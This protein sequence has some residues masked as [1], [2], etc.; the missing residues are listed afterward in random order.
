[1]LIY[2]KTRGRC[3]QRYHDGILGGN[4][5]SY[6]LLDTKMDLSTPDEYESA[7]TLEGRFYVSGKDFDNLQFVK[8]IKEM[9]NDILIEMYDKS[10]GMD[11]ELRIKKDHLASLRRFRK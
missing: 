2:R 10:L 5:L 11:W 1:M 7:E 4:V 6:F 3:R 9:G 8:K